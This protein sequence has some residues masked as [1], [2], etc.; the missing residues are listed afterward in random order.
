MAVNYSLT[1]KNTRMQAVINAIDAMPQGG[2]L[3]VTS[4]A[5]PY[6]VDLEIADSGSGLTEEVRR[7]AFEPFFTTKP[8]GTGLGLAI[9][10][11]IAEV[12]GGQVIAANCFEGGA[13][14]TIRIPR[15]TPKVAA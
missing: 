3:V 14:F 5:S 10:Y 11:R 7:R 13:A 1:A 2:E 6:A 4:Y 8:G 15:L 12:H 9:V